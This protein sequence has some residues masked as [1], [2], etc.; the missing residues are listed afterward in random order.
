MQAVSLHGLGGIGKTEL[1]LHIL[2]DEMVVARFAGRRYFIE[3]ETIATAPELRQ[4]IATAVGADTGAAVSFRD[5]VRTLAACLGEQSATL[6]VLDNLETTLEPAPERDDVRSL[7]SE[8]LNVDTVALVSTCRSA[9]APVPHRR[10]VADDGADQAIGGL[11]LGSACALFRAI[12]RVPDADGPALERLVQL[13]GGHAL[14]LE[15]LAAR[16]MAEGGDVRE[17]LE[18]FEL[19]G[20][21]YAASDE[22]AATKASS[23]VVSLRLSLHSTRMTPAA[24][25]LLSVLA[26][27]G[28]PIAKADIRKLQLHGRDSS[29]A[30]SSLLS[31]GLIYQ[32]HGKPYRCFDNTHSS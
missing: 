30:V 20:A 17:T 23:L 3:C 19:E 18:R 21:G 13:V 5:S 25:D 31:V 15:L 16:T 26:I 4:C 7:I 27:A 11:E 9:A 32:E 28:H 8:L 1:A 29:T 2:H 22:D 12:C 10:W 14:A 24:V 6:I